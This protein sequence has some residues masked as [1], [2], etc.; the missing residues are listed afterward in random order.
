[1]IRKYIPKKI[2]TD[3]LGSIVFVANPLVTKQSENQYRKDDTHA[4]NTI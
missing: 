3:N 1:M 4:V 2:N